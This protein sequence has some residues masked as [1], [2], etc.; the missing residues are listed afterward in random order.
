MLIHV[1]YVLSA[2]IF[3]LTSFESASYD[4]DLEDALMD[5][6][7]LLQAN[8]A[9]KQSSSRNHTG[10]FILDALDD[11]TL[12]PA[13]RAFMLLAGKDG[14][15][16]DTTLREF[17]VEYTDFDLWAIK[18]AF[19]V[20]DADGSR[21]LNIFELAKFLHN[22]EFEKNRR[23]SKDVTRVVCES[24]NCRKLP[25]WARP[26]ERSNRNRI[27]VLLWNPSWA[28]FW[29]SNMEHCGKAVLAALKYMMAFA[30][31]DFALLFGADYKVQIAEEILTG[32]AIDSLPTGSDEPMALFYKESTWDRMDLPVTDN[33]NFGAEN[34]YVSLEN[35][36]ARRIDRGP[37]CRIW[38]FQ[39]V[40]W[41]DP[42]RLGVPF[43][44]VLAGTRFPNGNN[45][46]AHAVN[47]G[48]ESTHGPPT[49]AI[50]LYLDYMRQQIRKVSAHIDFAQQT[51]LPPASPLL[52]KTLIMADMNNLL[53]PPE[54][55]DEI[56]FG[57]EEATFKLR[58]N[59][60]F[61]PFGATEFRDRVCCY[62]NNF[63]YNTTYIS[64]T[65]AFYRVRR[66][67]DACTYDQ[68]SYWPWHPSDLSQAK[69]PRTVEAP[70]PYASYS[71]R[72]LTVRKVEDEAKL[73]E[74]ERV[75]FVNCPICP[76]PTCPTTKT[77]AE[78]EATEDSL[79]GI[80]ASTADA[81][82]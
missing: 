2:F 27:I 15:I 24:V 80:Y 65:S 61:F 55:L 49:R 56:L 39:H 50:N 8:L 66:A 74:F 43:T 33:C 29:E 78:V 6:G 16:D 21:K 30:N 40:S 31:L 25:V 73:R 64:G 42:Y 63:K 9:S 60:T 69:L 17:M 12:S 53:F 67:Y 58:A 79:V 5:T 48:D 57:R 41:V 70:L 75:E 14:K 72:A 45:L 51:M 59:N 38:A 34:N 32:W 46:W 82:I 7:A 81:Q 37:A 4:A 76:M 52:Q 1:S 28:C 77:G 11:P 47:S 3:C 26:P 20:F 22:I 71:M 18:K 44:F 68:D 62:H 36:F 35:N 13:E 54:I 19:D 10:R 23:D